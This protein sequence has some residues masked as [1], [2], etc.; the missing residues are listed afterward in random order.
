[1]E[2][3]RTQCYSIPF[4]LTNG[5]CHCLPRTTG[6]PTHSPFPLHT[7]LQ[8]F[9]SWK[10]CMSE[11]ELKVLLISKPDLNTKNLWFSSCCCCFRTWRGR[12]SYDYGSEEM[13]PFAVYSDEGVGQ[14]GREQVGRTAGLLLS[15]CRCWLEGKVSECLWWCFAGAHP[16]V[17]HIGA[18]S[19]LWSTSGEVCIGH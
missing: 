15:I 12:K 10:R 18:P 19:P 11:G 6:V 5:P 2:S 13:G 7:G 14:G 8:S 16:N 3:Q 9:H 17:G 4:Q 1:M